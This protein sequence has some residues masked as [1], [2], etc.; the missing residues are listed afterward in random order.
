MGS[1]AH[2]RL[3]GCALVAG[4]LAAACG[5]PG[6]HQAE[7]TRV[8]PASAAATNPASTSRTWLI[9]GDSGSTGT[10]SDTP[11]P[12]SP[13]KVNPGSPVTE[14]R[15]EAALSL[16]PAGFVLDKAV[17]ISFADGTAS[18]TTNFIA[19]D[20]LGHLVV[21]RQQLSDAVPMPG[22]GTEGV[23][24]EKTTKGEFAIVNSR[25]AN[26]TSVFVTPDGLE[27]TASFRVPT[28]GPNANKVTSSLT[29]GDLT[30]LLTG[31]AAQP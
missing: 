30:R 11:P 21:T 16:L 4:A 20:G 3:A 24:Y 2:A 10:G 19:P 18:S 8:V 31:L 22:L 23:N 5:G 7:S 27:F 26:R 6:Q 17:D 13:M 1:Y 15:A 29:D 14:R 28:S 12:A 25:N 9:A